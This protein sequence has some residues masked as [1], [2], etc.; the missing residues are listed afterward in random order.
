VRD[1]L[2]R[3]PV[4][5]VTPVVDVAGLQALRAHARLTHVSDPVLQHAVAVVRATRQHRALRLGASARAAV[6]L[7]RCAQGR[8]LLAGRDFVTPDDVKALALPVLAHR[9]VPR[10][11]ADRARSAEVV[12]EV[13]AATPVPLG[14]P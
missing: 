6:A 3:P 12:T 10:D 8:A 11:G 7:V 9:V 4:D 1:Q 5:D 14:A 2:V 13:V